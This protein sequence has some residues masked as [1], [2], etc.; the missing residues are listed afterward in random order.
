MAATIKRIYKDVDYRFQFSLCIKFLSGK[1]L[2]Q[3]EK[4]ET[5]KTEKEKTI[6]NAKEIINR[7]KKVKVD[8]NSLKPYYWEKGLKKRIYIKVFTPGETTPETAG[9]VDLKDGC[10][11]NDTKTQPKDQAKRKELTTTIRQVTEVFKKEFYTCPYD[12]Q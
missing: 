5:V 7:L 3:A 10:Y 12:L 9:Y 8:G 1:Q 11:F 6:E 4:K 2:P